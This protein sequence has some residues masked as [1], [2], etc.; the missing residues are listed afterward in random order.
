MDIGVGQHWSVSQQCDL[1]R[2]RCAGAIRIERQ[3]T[4]RCIVDE[5][6]RRSSRE[7]IGGRGKMTGIKRAG[8]GGSRR[9]IVFG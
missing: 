6:R 8:V 7:A 5:L 2:R 1:H 3:S 4:G 9:H